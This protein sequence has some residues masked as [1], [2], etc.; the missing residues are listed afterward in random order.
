MN[1]FGISLPKH[2]ARFELRVI[3]ALALL[4]AAALLPALANARKELR[5][6]VRRAHLASVKHAIEMF[7]NKHEAYPA[8]P[9]RDRVPTSPDEGGRVGGNRLPQCASSGKE[10]D[11]LFGRDGPLWKEKFLT[12]LP[13]DPRFP[14]KRFLQY[15]VT[16][17]DDRGATAWYLRVQL[18][19]RQRPRAAFNAETGHNF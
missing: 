6:G 11:W 7:F 5:D 10:D 19:R 13:R 8:P 4:F 9:V 1:P 12:D 17:A 15:C 16:D 14:R 2:T 3:T 18:E